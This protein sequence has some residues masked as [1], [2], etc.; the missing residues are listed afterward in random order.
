[1]LIRLDHCPTRAGLLLPGDRF[2]VAGGPYYRNHQGSRTAMAAH[3]PLVFRAFCHNGA[4]CWIEA[5]GPD[6]VCVLHL[7]PEEE[8]PVVPGLI[9]RP[10]RVTRIIGENVMKK[11]EVHIGKVYTARVTDRLVPV[12]ID[13]ENRHGGWDG[14]NLATN[15]RVRINS[16]QRLRARATAEQLRAVA[17]QAGE[18][19]GRGERAEAP[20]G[21][22]ETK[23]QPKQPAKTDKPAD[24]KTDKADNPD[25]KSK[26]AEKPK[27]ASG[28][29]AAARVLAEA[30]EPM[31]VKD[32][33]QV[34]FERGYWKSGG[35]TPS[36][37][38]YS[39]IIREIAAKGAQS[40]FKK[41][42]RGQFAANK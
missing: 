21:T 11:S 10:Y 34:A 39:A 16:A 18:Q 27:K 4:R 42:G 38:V 32:I 13:G 5:L 36:A 22:A 25:K 9:R 19:N 8:S 1:M 6:G 12:R 3:G 23:A 29:D 28:L 33:V 20:N 37:T 35:K 24:V 15:K 14:T 40:R 41:A 26:K 31:N 30:S 17:K 7:G 2:A